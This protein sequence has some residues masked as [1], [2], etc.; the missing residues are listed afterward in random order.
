MWTQ[1]KALI[2]LKVAFLGRKE[3]LKGEFGNL[4]WSNP[5][6]KIGMESFKIIILNKKKEELKMGQLEV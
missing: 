6:Y 1:F 4:G 2:S 3:C 5:E